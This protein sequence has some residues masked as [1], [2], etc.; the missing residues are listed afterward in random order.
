[1]EIE[2]IQGDP[3]APAS[4]M[5]LTMAKTYHPLFGKIPDTPHHRLATEEL[6]LRE[7]AKRLPGESM[8]FGDGPGGRL[9][10]VRPGAQIRRR[11]A[12]TYGPH[13]LTLRFSYSFPAH[14]RRIMG[15]PAGEVLGN[16]LTGLSM[17]MFEAVTLEKIEA[18]ATHLQHRA[19]LRRKMDEAGLVAFFAEGSVAAR[20]ADGKP[21]ANARP[22]KVPAD[23]ATEIVLDDGTKLRGLGIPKG[24]TVLAGS[25]FHGKTT[26]LEAISEASNELSMADGLAN[27]CSV[28]K[29]E[30]VCVEENRSVA[31][32]D[33]SPFF[34][35]LPGQD[36]TEFVVDEASGATSQAANLH[37]TLASGAELLLVD[38]DASAANFL[39]RDPRMASLLPKGES[40]VPFVARARELAER[41]VSLV[42]V[43]GASSEWLAVA[44]RVIVLSEY[45]PMDATAKAREVVREAAIVVGKPAPADWARALAD[46][47]MDKWK[48]L[49][50]LSVAKIRVQD[51]LVRVGP[52]AESR[53]PRRFAE[54][55]SLRAAAMLLAEWLRFCRDRNLAPRR[56]GMMD[57][58]ETRGKSVDPWGSHVGHDLAWPRNRET[59]ALWTRLRATGKTDPFEDE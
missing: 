56:D 23:L 45:Q 55:D 26:L 4:R 59:W 49:A 25:A 11:S 58:L 29:T 3:Y 19:E 28:A 53:L 8:P 30:F 2:H 31:V 1:L 39:T 37:E 44:D 38:E 48:D 18:M 13:G 21:I 35:S 14:S 46:Q 54:D 42:V 32:C 33:L 16:R 15:E 27:A 43:A 51:G 36:P 52:S 22:L 12:V 5:K 10:T 24:I 50:G 7:F 6:F 20:D 9:K 41:G 17:D 47:G 57:F 34:R 40:V